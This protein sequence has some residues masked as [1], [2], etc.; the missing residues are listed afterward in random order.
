M[1]KPQVV[2]V[3]AGAAGTIVAIRL[4]ESEA[5]GR[6]TLVERS[7]HVSLGTAYSTVEDCHRLNV[8]AAEMSLWPERPGHFVQWLTAEGLGDASVATKFVPRRWFG[9]YLKAMLAVAAAESAAELAVVHG[10]AVS[11][12]RE[13]VGLQTGEQIFADHV[14]LALGNLPPSLPS[15]MT[16][17]PRERVINPWAPHAL[18]RI[19][20]DERILIVGAGLTMV[21][22]VLSLCAQGHRGAIHVRS[23]HGLAPRAH[24]CPSCLPVDLPPG[25]Q[26]LRRAIDIIR[27]GGERWRDVIDALRPRTN[28]LWQSLSWDGRGRFKQRLQA[29]WDV[30]RHRIPE[31]VAERLASLQSNGCLEIGKGAVIDA[32]ERSGDLVVRFADEILAV[33]WVINCSGPSGSLRSSRV[34]IVELAVAA[35]LAEYDPLGIGL[36]VDGAGR[37]SPDGHVWAIGALCRGCRLETTAIP[38]IRCQ[39]MEIATVICR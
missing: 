2:I 19:A 29:Y 7:V 38:E 17:L 12:S 30:H 37:T 34:P 11:V 39:A 28:E 3:G 5:V 1:Q 13:T 24:A 35:G 33:D 15:S 18:Q 14:V 6:V 21:D 4:L 27:G 8:R 20:S 31:D 32:L 36:M 9:R 26:L 16:G 10:E 23:R 25:D 22:A